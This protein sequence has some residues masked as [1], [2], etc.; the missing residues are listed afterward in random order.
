MSCHDYHNLFQ[1][2]S[3]HLFIETTSGNQED[4]EED[5]NV[6]SNLAAVTPL[7]PEDE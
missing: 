2:I 4:K 5:N 3:L 6:V 1:H 7:N